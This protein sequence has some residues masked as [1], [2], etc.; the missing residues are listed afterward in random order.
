MK[1]LDLQQLEEQIRIDFEIV[2]DEIIENEN[3]I[4]SLK[5]TRAT[6]SRGTGAPG[7]SET[8]DLWVDETV[9]SEKLYVKQ[10]DG[11]YKYV[12]LT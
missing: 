8:V 1:E 12:A 9:S 5:D 7:S 6:I 3:D 4:S 2:R 11:S 10:S